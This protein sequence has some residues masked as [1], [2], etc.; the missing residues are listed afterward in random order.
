MNVIDSNPHAEPGNIWQ[1]AALGRSA[2]A[3]RADSPDI[4]LSLI[5]LAL[6]DGAIDPLYR[7]HHAACLKII[8][9]FAEAEKFYWEIL[10]EHPESVEAMQGLRALYHAV[11][12]CGVTPSPARR[13]QS[14]RHQ[15]A[16][17]WYRKAALQLRN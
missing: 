6:A 2:A 12:Q 15:T 11:G 5:E 7:Y 10:R 8:G 14:P 13:A 16:R 1:Q 4:A 17:H 3:L 9:R